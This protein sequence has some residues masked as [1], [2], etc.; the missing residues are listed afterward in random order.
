MSNSHHDFC[1]IG[2]GPAGA[3]VA[4]E[5]SQKGFRVLVIEAGGTAV[6]IDP[7]NVLDEET[8]LIEGSINLGFSQQVGGASNLWA[9]GI[10]RFNPIDLGPRAEFGLTGWPISLSELGSYYERVDDYIGLPK[11]GNIGE[12]GCGE[13]PDTSR[14]EPREIR[15]LDTPFRTASLLTEG[16][17]IR[18]LQNSPAHRLICDE[19]G[20]AIREVEFYDRASDSHR[21][22]SADVFVVAAGT[23]TNIRLLLH[24]LRERRDRLANTY[25]RIG[26]AVSTHPKANVGFLHLN[27]ALPQSHPFVAVEKRQGHRL[28][29][30]FGLCENCLQSEGLLNH[31]LRFDSSYYQSIDRQFERLTRVVGSLPVTRRGGALS[32]L[33]VRLGTSTFRALEKLRRPSSRTLTIR[34]F[35]DQAARAENRVT[36][37]E[38]RSESGLPLAALNW[39]FTEEDWVIAEKFM[40]VF[41]EEVRRQGIGS[42]AYRRPDPKEFTAVHSHFIGGTP[43]GSDAATTV[44][45]PNLCVHGVDNL[46]VCGPSVFPSYGY[47]NPFYTIAALSIRL[48]DHLAS[49]LKTRGQ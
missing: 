26:R 48:A 6:D 27:Q 35:L 12:Y 4:H 16:R 34:M 15:V 18:L 38:R 17:G 23:L 32:E 36:L 41:A 9:G 46:Y 30:Q 24:S 10:V 14:I 47:A 44:V 45:D 2:T 37:S 20:T 49:V 25:E 43:M 7:A 3:F 29:Y 11:A 22:A 39:R 28:R 8:S 21:R 19:R 13:G 33:I 1:I 31:C 40:A 42:I 5:L